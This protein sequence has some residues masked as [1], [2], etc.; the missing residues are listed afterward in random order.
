[1]AT[2][3]EGIGVTAEFAATS[4][5]L[6]GLA[7]EADPSAQQ[8]ALEVLLR[9]YVAP[10][11][12]HLVARKRLDPHVAEDLVQDF[13]AEKILAAQIVQR[14]VRE[15]GKFRTFLLV[16]LDRFVSNRL[17]DGRAAKRSPGDRLVSVGE[18][19]GDLAGPDADVGHAFDVD[20]ARAVLDE[21][22]GRMRQS[23]LASGRQ[24]LWDLFDDRV[25]GPTLHARPPTP[26]AELAARFSFGSPT[27]AGNAVLT[28]R[29]MFVRFLHDVIAE[30]ARDESD[31]QD[32]IADL[33]NVLARR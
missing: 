1:M 32:E 25:V 30:Y 17:R 20:W 27:E 31:V 10:L 6:V 19:T 33:H 29:R 16:A 4:W 18:A 22:L 3:P 9:R 14:A 11:R 8:R 7:S 28:G 2:S 26:Y 23:C 15:R 24:R 13:V 12:S 21:T 5:T